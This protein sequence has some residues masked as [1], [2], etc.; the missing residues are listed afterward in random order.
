M[1]EVRTPPTRLVD[2]NPKW[3]REQ[4]G[5]IWGIRYDCPCGKRGLDGGT[6]PTHPDVIDGVC[7][8]GG[9]AIVPTKTN[10][11]GA[12]SCDDSKARGWDLTGDSFE[13]VTL[14]PSIH[15]VG[16]WHGFLTNGVLTSC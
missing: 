14:A 11:A 1:S 4:G 5:K 7:P 2:L 15:H 8:M 10:F 16:H 13:N 6:T 9:W 3:I 12:E